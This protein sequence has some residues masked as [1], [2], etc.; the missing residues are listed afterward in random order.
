MQI[1][2]IGLGFTGGDL[3]L[4]KT[5]HGVFVAGKC[6]DRGKVKAINR[7][8]EVKTIVNGGLE[9]PVSRHTHEAKFDESR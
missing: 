7:K 4:N 3:S 8:P 5:D 2:I 1:S 9:V 6:K